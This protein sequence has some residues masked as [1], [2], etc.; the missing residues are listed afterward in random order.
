MKFTGFKVVPS[1][2]VRFFEEGEFHYE[3]ADDQDPTAL[4]IARLA[5]VEADCE[6]PEA[7][8]LRWAPGSAHMA[9]RDVD[10]EEGDES[11]VSGDFCG[12]GAILQA[13]SEQ[14]GQ[15]HSFSLCEGDFVD[16]IEKMCDGLNALLAPV[17]IV[18]DISGGAIH[19][20][21]ADRP[22]VVL[23]KSDD[24]DDVMDF[25]ATHGEHSLLKSMGDGH[26]AHWVKEAELFSDI[27]DHYHN[28]VKPC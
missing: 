20:T 3:I 25:E 15:V 19:G 22:A 6:L 9:F 21:Y 1:I 17:R 11:P 5:E 14:D 26:V 24:P 2:R 23:Y 8:E 18:A 13:S 28:Q 7:I 10:S 27:V 12:F 16:R 4:E